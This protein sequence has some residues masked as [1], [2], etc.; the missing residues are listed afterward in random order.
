M[1]VAVTPG[2]GVT[3]KSSTSGLDQVPHHNIDV[4][5]NVLSLT[6][7]MPTSPNA[8]VTVLP[9]MGT[10]TSGA[11]AAGDFVDGKLTLANI[12]PVAGGSGVIQAVKV[13]SKSPQVGAIY[14]VALFNADPTGTTIA[15]NGVGSIV[16]ADMTKQ[17]GV[18]VCEQVGPVTA[19]STHQAIGLG[20]PFKLPSGTTA[21]AAVITAGA[22]TQ[23]STSDMI[24]VVDVLPD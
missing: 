10:Q 11:Y 22:I 21:Y 2:S 5:G 16:D 1:S 20:M 12:V 19:N 18:A 4:G 15:D 3:L 17:I 9:T 6:N 23:T 8:A 7:R 24:L 13:F 14:W